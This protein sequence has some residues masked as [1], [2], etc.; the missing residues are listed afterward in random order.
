MNVREFARLLG[1]QAKPRTQGFDLPGDRRG[2]TDTTWIVPLMFAAMP[3]DGEFEFEDS[4]SGLCNGGRHEGINR[5]RYAHPFKL[6]V[7][8]KNLETY[9]K[10]QV[11]QLLPRLSIID[12]DAE[13]CDMRILQSISTVLS[14][15]RSFIK[16]IKSLNFNVFGFGTAG[17]GAVH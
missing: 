9:L 8:G 11:P 10:T 14:E 7:A 13:G 5:R 2:E 1:V 16:E 17:P 4:D 3:G 12:V 6:R 15:C